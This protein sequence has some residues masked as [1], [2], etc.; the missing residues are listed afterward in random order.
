MN[1][2]GGRS[3]NASGEVIDDGLP[4]RSPSNAADGGSGGMP[5]GSQS[6]AW[7]MGGQG[8]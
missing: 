7:V 8:G 2:K 5:P 6:Y 3:L 4:P 1:G